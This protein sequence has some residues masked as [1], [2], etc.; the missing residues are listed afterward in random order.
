MINRNFYQIICHN[1]VFIGYCLKLTNF[2]TLQTNN[3]NKKINKT[4]SVPI[5]KE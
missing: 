2:F 3:F 1:F 4:N 5:Y